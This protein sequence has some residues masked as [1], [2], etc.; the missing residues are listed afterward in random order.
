MTATT[1]DSNKVWSVIGKVAV[2]I[3]ALLAA[4]QLYDSFSVKK[5]Q[6]VARASASEIVSFPNL[7][8]TTPF[9]KADEKNEKEKALGQAIFDCRQ[10]LFQRRQYSSYIKYEI[11]NT[12]EREAADLRLEVPFSGFYITVKDDADVLRAAELGLKPQKFE[13]EITLQTIRPKNKLFIHVWPTLSNLNFYFHNYQY[14]ESSRITYPE[15]TFTVDYSYIVSGND[16]KWLAY[17]PVIL[18]FSM[19]PYVFL[20]LYLLYRYIKK[21]RK[22]IQT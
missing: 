15:G 16:T 14:D 5:V 4:K 17:Q 13:K 18:F 9:A 22:S 12:G 7:E 20:L 19:A 11:E 1:Q 3:T 2:V 8:D 21:R 10:A 6:L